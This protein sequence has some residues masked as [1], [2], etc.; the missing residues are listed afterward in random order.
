MTFVAGQKLRASDLNTAFTAVT[1]L[2]AIKT[3]DEKVNNTTTLQADDELFVAVAAN[4]TY[5]MRCQVFF[6]SGVTPDIKFGW[7]GPA[8][9]AMRWGSLDT[10]NTPWGQ[11]DIG[12]AL[13]IGAAGSDEFA[14]FVGL[15]QVAGAGGN[16]QLTWAQN[17]ATVSD[18]WVRAKS[19][20]V[21]TPIT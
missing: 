10:F 6:N 20:I 18:T 3:I 21:L 19:Y 2:K 15:L 7:T 9:A 4:A 17:G 12:N 16:L 1:S 11:K 14:L 8:G 13:A 5:A